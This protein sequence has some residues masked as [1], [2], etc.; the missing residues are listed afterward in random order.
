[1]S[2]EIIVVDDGSADRSPLIVEELQRQHPEILLV[3]HSNNQGKGAA[4][5][6]ALERAG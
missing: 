2:L 6:S 5:R 4:I 3:R 1:M